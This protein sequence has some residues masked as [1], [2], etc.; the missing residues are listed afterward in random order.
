MPRYNPFDLTGKVALVTGANSGIGF[1]F[2]EG[3][4]RAGADLAIWGRRAE[5][6]E[7]AAEQLR[8]HGGRVLPLTCD[9]SDKQQVDESFAQTVAALGR[10]DSCF[11]NAGIG[12]RGTPFVEMTDREWQEIFAVNMHGAF[13]TLQAAVRH[14]VERGG[15]GS[16]VATSSSSA[17]FGAPRSEH[18]AATKAGLISIVRA[19]AVEH[20]RHGIRANAVLPGWIESEMT[21]RVMANPKFVDR[22]LPRVPQRRWGTGAD[23]AGIAVYFAG[24]ASAYHTGDSVVIDGGYACF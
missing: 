18:Y 1:G 15:G 3:L 14:M 7:E 23:F 19:L 10:V 17:I 22:V 2:A 4:A 12:S 6:N 8:A 21:A 9:V 11:A 16:L 20:A 5:R 24:D 13:Y